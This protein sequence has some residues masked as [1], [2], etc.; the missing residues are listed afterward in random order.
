MI[1]LDVEPYC[2]NTNCDQFE[3]DVEYPC[4]LYAGFESVGSVGET[5]IR[6]QKRKLCE[7]LRK[8]ILDTKDGG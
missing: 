7:R 2:H 1:I 8:Y 4:D 5:V 6:C 3:P